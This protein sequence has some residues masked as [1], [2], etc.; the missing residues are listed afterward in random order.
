MESLH[1]NVPLS[2]MHILGALFS[3]LSLP[4][5]AGTFPR[6]SAPASAWPWL[7]PEPSSSC[8]LRDHEVAE[9]QRGPGPAPSFGAALINAGLR[10]GERSRKLVGA[11]AGPGNKVTATPPE[12]E[13]KLQEEEEEEGE[14]M[15]T[16]RGA[17]AAFWCRF[18]A[19]FQM[20]PPLQMC[21]GGSSSSLT[22]GEPL[23]A[24]IPGK[25]KEEER[26]GKS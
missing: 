5:P 23:P 7:L 13:E 15:G 1:L 11:G 2:V 20:F 4:F 10:V 21:R 16:Q 17:P 22:Q 18:S 19:P 8:C 9:G 25:N 24:Q 12:W 14:E 3:S 6:R 26:W